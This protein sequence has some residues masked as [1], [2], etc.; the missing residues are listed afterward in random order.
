M[1]SQ[2]DLLFSFMRRFRT[3][4][5][6]VWNYPSAAAQKNQQGT[7]LLRI[8]IDRRGNVSDVQ[9]LESSGH[10]VLDEEA[11]T[12]VR[13]GATYG[14]LA[15]ILPHMRPEDHG[16]LRLSSQRQHQQVFP[17]EARKYLLEI[18]VAIPPPLIL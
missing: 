16:L 1:D 7:C 4:I 13:Q 3:N 17:T 6:N 10:R 9:L 18:K 2:Q 14:P 12:A 8:T 15:K 5:Y 11:M